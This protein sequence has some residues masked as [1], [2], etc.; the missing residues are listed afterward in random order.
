MMLRRISDAMSIASECMFNL[1]VNPIVLK[2]I[3]NLEVVRVDENTKV[4]IN[5]KN[6]KKLIIYI[7][8][9][10]LSAFSNAFSRKT[11][12]CKAANLIKRK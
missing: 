12:L 8:I 9:I 10:F 2:K 7:F 1:Q 4:K 11:T 3:M 6:R 5:A